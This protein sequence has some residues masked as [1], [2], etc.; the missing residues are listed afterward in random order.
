L[1]PRLVSRGDIVARKKIEK[2]K[3]EVLKVLSASTSKGL[4]NIKRVVRG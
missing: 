1:I 3:K 2:M 4:L